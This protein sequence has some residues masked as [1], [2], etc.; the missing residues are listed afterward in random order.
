MIH[1]SVFLSRKRKFITNAKNSGNSMDLQKT[2]LLQ[3]T[4]LNILGFVN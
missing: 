3:L 4:V 1:L 2:L